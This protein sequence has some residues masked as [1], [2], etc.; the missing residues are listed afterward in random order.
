MTYSETLDY[1]FGL[2]VFGIR[3]GLESINQLLERVGNPHRHLRFIHVAGT[4]GKGSVSA[5]IHAI[6]QAAGYNAGLYTSPHLLDFTER[7]QVGD[8]PIPVEEVVRLTD[9][10]RARSEGLICTFFE[11]TT[12]LAFLY[13]L[14]QNADPVVVEVGMGGRLDATNVVTP[15]VSVITTISL[16]HAEYLGRMLRDIA[17]EK[18][19]I[20]KPGVPAVTTATQRSV[21]SILEAI[22]HERGAPLW[23]INRDFHVRG[24]SRRNFAYTGQ[25]IRMRRLETGMA[26]RYQM[27][28]AAAAL[29]S[30]ELLSSEGFSFT[31]E[32]IR[33]GLREAFLPGRLQVVREKPMVVLDGA[34]NPGKACQL[35]R[36]IREEFSYRSL[37]LV[38]GIMRDKD[39]GGVLRYL[40]PMSE[41]IFLV[42]PKGPR[43]ANPEALR[44]MLEKRWGG[45]AYVAGGVGP[46][47]SMAVED[48]HPDDLILVCGSFYTVAEALESKAWATKPEIATQ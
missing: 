27:T 32:Q 42:R 23:R 48:A 20:I 16:D 5:F 22:C 34:H 3:P 40:A 31:E 38:F 25:S 29:A 26:G 36:A 17:F 11:F 2:E 47:V 41:R 37:R 28:N 8:S 24:R 14:E 13:F 1:L 6:F 45:A 43:A 9:W 33:R 39:A 21:I 18:S 35:A 44:M 15:C 10:M 12:A 4:S 30:I 7:I 19:G 46:G